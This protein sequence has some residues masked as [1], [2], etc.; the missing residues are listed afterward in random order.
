[1]V[2]HAHQ[3]DALASRIMGIAGCILP[4]ITKPASRLIVFMSSELAEG[5]LLNMSAK[6]LEAGIVIAGC[7]QPA[8]MFTLIS[9]RESGSQRL[10]CSVLD[11]LPA[12]HIWTVSIPGLQS[13]GSGIP[14]SQH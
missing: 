5:N 10:P 6:A 13:T 3:V 8:K 2:D 9:C 12:V 7:V 14:T 1:V 4:A 11:Q